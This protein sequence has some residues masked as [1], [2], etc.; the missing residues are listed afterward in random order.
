VPPRIAV[1]V[2]DPRGIGP[3]IV[4]QVLSDPPPG[5][6]YIV[7]GPDELIRDLPA[8]QVPIQGKSGGWDGT[9]PL[10]P[11]PFPPKEAGYITAKQVE[12][13]VSLALSG[14]VQAVVTGPAEKRALHLAGYEVPGHTEW[15][16]EL[17]GG[18][19]TSMML[20]TG[21]LRVVLLTTHIAL[22]DVPGAVTHELI[23]RKGQMTRKALMDWWGIADPRIAVCALNPHASEGGLFGTEDE[24]ILAPAA[25]ELGAA[26]P[27]PAD[28]VFVRALNGEFDAVL[29]PSH[30]VGMTAVKV[31]GFGQGVNITLG[32][33]FVRTSPDHG[34][35]F[36]I[37]GK[38]VA[39][40]SSMREAVRL[41][42]KLAGRRRPGVG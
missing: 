38:G 5:A 7:I 21:K 41:A 4:A 15:L 3:E 35:A 42:V 39:D 29:T 6:E 34:T 20:A 17:A 32:L 14:D 30:D 8:E 10:S 19:E 24:E 12:K 25:R 13:A 1:T 9:F 18:V 33:P 2:G 16:G 36:D 27:L 26:G 28:T 11:F 23:V 40:P 22:K 37:A 31:A